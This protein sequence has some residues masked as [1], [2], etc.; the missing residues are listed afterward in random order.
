MKKEKLL[1]SFFAPFLVIPLA[2]LYWV[3]FYFIGLLFN[4]L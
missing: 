3:A 4:L 2:V 1:N